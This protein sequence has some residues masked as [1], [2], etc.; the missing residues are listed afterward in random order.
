MKF[1]QLLSEGI[2]QWTI[3]NTAY[4]ALSIMRQRSIIKIVSSFVTIAR[5]GD[6]IRR[7]ENGEY[8]SLED[9]TYE[10]PDGN[11]QALQRELDKELK[12]GL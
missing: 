10:L 3:K 7:L 12:K 11:R 2:Q 1:R 8:S 5:F 6:Q 4:D 9:F